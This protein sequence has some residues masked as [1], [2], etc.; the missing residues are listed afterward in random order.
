MLQ[1]VGGTFD[2]IVVLG[3][4]PDPSVHYLLTMDASQSKEFRVIPPIDN[5]WRLRCYAHLEKTGIRSIP[6]WLRSCWRQKTL[7]PLRWR[8]TVGPPMIVESEFIT[9]VVPSASDAAAR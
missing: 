8:S 9:N 2:P 6:R 3:Q 4:P 5:V 7:V 1:G